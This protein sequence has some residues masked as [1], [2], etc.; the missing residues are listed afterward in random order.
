MW[1]PIL[2]LLGLGGIALELLTPGFGVP[3]AVGLLSFGSIFGH[4]LASGRNGD[5]AAL[6]RRTH[7]DGGRVVC[8]RVGIF[9]ILGL[10]S[11][12]APW[13][14]RPTIPPSVSLSLLVALA[15]TLVG[16]WIA[17]KVFGMKGAWAKIIL[18]ESQ[19][20]ESG[21]TSSR[22]RKDLVGKKGMTLTPLRPAGWVQV[23]GEKYDVVS[24]GGMIPA[25]RR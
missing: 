19:Q 10:I 23:D 18:K 1:F 7:I 20:N 16:V 12:E 25:K 4:Y 9:G 8:A 15:I 6:C 21:Y 2:L 22:D 11:L 13:C 14:W 17:V 3:G 24:E 5:G